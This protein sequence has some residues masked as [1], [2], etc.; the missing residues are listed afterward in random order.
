MK[1]TK[2]TTVAL[3]NNQ[4][5]ILGGY[6]GIVEAYCIGFTNGKRDKKLDG[7]YFKKELKEK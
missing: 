2:Y 3:E 7:Y 6:I 4:Y 5:L 1:N